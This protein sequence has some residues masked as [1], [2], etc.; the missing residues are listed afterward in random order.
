MV[1]SAPTRSAVADAEADAPPG[2]RV[3]LRDGEELDRQV[4]RAGRP[5]RCWAPACRRAA[6]R[7]RR[8]RRSPTAPR[9]RPARRPSCRTRVDD[10]AG[11]VV[12]EVDD[13]AL[14]LA[15]RARQRLFDLGV[16]VA[17]GPGRDRDRLAAGDDDA[18]AVDRI[19]GVGRQ[20]AVAGADDRQQ[21]VGEPLLRA[22]GDDRLAVGVEA[23]GRSGA[24]TSRRSPC[25]ARA[26]PAT[27]CSAGCRRRLRRLD[28]RSTAALGARAVGVAEAEVEDVVPLGAQPRLQLV[29]G[30]EDVGRQRGEALEPCRVSKM[31]RPSRGRDT[32]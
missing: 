6:D 16:S 4:A 11:R 17:A 21:Q 5:G 31:G 2:H 8:D 26:S 25:A 24:R 30:R 22:D 9:A 20:H 15:R 13:Q 12:R 19:A 18:V 7:R 1:V 28:R 10:G 29:D 27:A 23:S 3:A 32:T 14:G